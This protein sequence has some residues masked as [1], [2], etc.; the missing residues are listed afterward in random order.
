MSAAEATGW[1]PTRLAQ[2]TNAHRE[3]ASSAKLDAE[4]NQVIW[5]RLA[6]DVSYTQTDLPSR[7]E[8]RVRGIR[9]RKR[10]TVVRMLM[11]DS[12]QNVRL[13]P[14]KLSY[15]YTVRRFLRESMRVDLSEK[16]L[17]H[18]GLWKAYR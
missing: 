13:E 4:V 15:W 1:K 2:V 5:G 14:R 18:A 11:C 3:C 16:A 9:R 7:T 10:L 8:R 12:L 17:H 6:S